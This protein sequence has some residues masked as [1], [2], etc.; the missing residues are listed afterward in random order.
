VLTISKLC[1]AFGPRDL[2]KD[3]DLQIAARDRVAL[4]GPNGAGKTTLLDMIVGDQQPD[5]GE[6]RLVRDAVIGYLRQE[7]N[8]LRGRSLLEEV[9]SVGAEV[10]QAGHRLQI[11]EE[12]MGETPP[13]P[14]LDRLVAEYGRLQDR[15]ATLG[16]YTLEAEAKKILSGLGFHEPDFERRTESFS[17]GWL[18]RVALAKLLLLS[19]DLLMLDEPTNHLDVESVEWLERF[20]ATYDGAV[21]LISHDRDFID[22]IATKV[23]EIDRAKLVSYTG[24]YADFVAQR[25]AVAEQ[26]AA[27]AKNQARQRAATEEFINRFRYKATKAKQVQSRIKALERMEKVDV[28][29]ERRRKMNLSFPVP[30]RPGRVVVELK[31]VRF[32][33]GEQPVYDSLDLALERGQKIALAGPNGAGK[34]TLLKLIAGALEPQVGERRLGHNVNLAYFAQHQIEALDPRNR[35]L[36][37]LASAIPAGVNVRPRDL[38]GRFM[39]SG[40]DVDKPVAV[41]SGGERTRLALAKLLVSPANVLCL[42]EPTNHLDIWSRDVLEDA[43]TEYQGTLVLITHDR[44]LIRSVANRV[45]EVVAGKVTHYDGDYDYYL[46]EREREAQT[47]AP[48]RPP[49][50]PPAPRGKER[51]RQEVEARARTQDL[52]RKIRK[53]ESQLDEVGAEL[54]RLSAVLADPGV[55]DSGADI[56]ALVQEYERTKKRTQALESSWEE[57][58]SALEMIE[59]E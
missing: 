18:M 19:P 31:D 32:G 34:T 46:S 14:D 48:A 50:T 52:R 3:A 23:V 24:D 49:Q 36:E 11:L 17:G 2:F 51:R 10:T 58:A 53:I 8:D 45:I 43:L 16:G 15:F 27:A 40:D 30:P 25:A 4:V 29:Q 47:D 5:S 55:Y 37:E 1:K 20:L 42:D 35:V 6:I 9:L 44:H 57:A 54:Q 33:Y 21:L 28:P 13:G 7:T 12:E 38:L 26:A 59:A 41:L 22:G 39:F 56:K